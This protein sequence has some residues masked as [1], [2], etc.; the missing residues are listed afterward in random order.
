MDPAEGPGP[1]DEDWSGDWETREEDEAEPARRRQLEE[2]ER[3]RADMERTAGEGEG[4][5]PSP[6]HPDDLYL[7]VNDQLTCDQDSTANSK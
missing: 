1:D 2:W 3:R 7:K 6:Y 4:G 5:R